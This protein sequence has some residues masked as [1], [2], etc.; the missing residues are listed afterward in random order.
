MARSAIFTALQPARM[1]RRERDTTHPR[2]HGRGH[3]RRSRNGTRT[4]RTR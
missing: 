4:D 1:S 2:K 3:D